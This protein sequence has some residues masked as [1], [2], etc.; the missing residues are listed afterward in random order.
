MVSEFNDWIFDPSRRT[1][2]S[3]IV[4]TSYG[5]HIIYFIGEGLPRWRADVETDLISEKYTALYNDLV[6]KYTITTSEF[7]M[8]L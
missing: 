7:A 8:K 5:Y 4:E 1:G 3:D 2:D 6:Q